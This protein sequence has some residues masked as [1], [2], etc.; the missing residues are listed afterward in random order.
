MSEKS[1]HNA[2][3]GRLDDK[4]RFRYGEHGPWFHPR[5]GAADYRNLIDFVVQAISEELEGR[6]DDD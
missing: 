5:P 2:I 4:I 1:L 3:M 6:A